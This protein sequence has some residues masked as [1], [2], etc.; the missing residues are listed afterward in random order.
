M[1]RVG[2][3]YISMLTLGERPLDTVVCDVGKDGFLTSDKWGPWWWSSGQRADDP[4]SNPAKVCCFLCKMLS[5]KG[6]KITIKL[7]GMSS[8]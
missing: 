3:V 6:R 7:A 8:F 4:S 1:G 5:E 2:F